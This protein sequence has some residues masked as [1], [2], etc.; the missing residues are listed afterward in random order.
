MLHEITIE[1]N[2]KEK[3]WKKEKQHLEENN[4]TTR[5]KS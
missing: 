1:I 5:R 4:N 2:C 3:E